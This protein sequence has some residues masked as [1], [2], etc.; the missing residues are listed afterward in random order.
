[1]GSGTRA[2]RWAL[3][4]TAAAFAA[5]PTAAA[6]AHGLQDRVLHTSLRAAAVSPGSVYL[7]AA[8]GESV[9]VSR[10]SAAADPTADQ[11]LVDSLGSLLHGP[12]LGALRVHVGSAPE[13]SRLC[14]GGEVVACY[15][16]AEARI[17]LP[18]RPPGGVQ[19][20]YLLAHEYGHHVAAWRTNEPWSAVDWGPKHWASAMG[21]CGQVRRG[22]LFPGNQGAHYREDP[23]EGFADAYAHL[24]R[25][26]VPW[27]FSPLLRPDRRAFAAVRRDVLR[28]WTGPR[29]RVLRGRLGPR[30]ESRSFRI[31]MALDG[32]VWLR[33]AAPRGVRAT[34]EVASRDRAIGQR[35][36]GGR[37]VGVEWCRRRPV[38]QVQVTVRRHSGAGRFALR[39]SWPG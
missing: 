27:R 1:V 35:L 28:P 12:E 29:T 4:T 13:I 24:H 30:H 7:A 16:V 6:G 34:V 33:L 17:Y 3:A 31:R 10:S 37:G 23:G 39:V 25:P 14:G 5:L 36:R 26:D 9:E 32:D 15:G 18:E 22:R 20:D 21:V 38:E 19:F 8:G 11:A 2:C